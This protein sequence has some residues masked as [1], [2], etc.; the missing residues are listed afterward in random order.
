MLPWLAARGGAATAELAERFGV[1]EP[2]VVAIL[3]LAAC[4]G[5]P[6]YT[7]DRLMEVI[8]ADGWVEARLGPHLGRPR[9]LSAAEGFTVAASARA[10]LAVPGADPDGALARALCKL[11]GVLGS[12]V[13]VELDEPSFLPV[14][15]RAVEEGSALELR[16]YA[17]SRDELTSRR[18]EPS[19]VFAREGHWYLDAWC[20]LAGGRRLFRVDR[21]RQAGVVPGEEAAAGRAGSER[22]EVPETFAP[23]PEAR[24]VTLDLP[25]EGRWVTE[26]YPTQGLEEAADG[27]LRVVLAVGG[28]A[29][30]ERLLLRLGPEAVVVDPPE[31]ADVAASAATRLLA[32]YG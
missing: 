12:T 23:G 22:R 2:E 3:E 31:L 10:I 8:V 20:H 16:Y 5:L 25:P 7:P 32:R 15:R 28:V 24:L 13:D 1:E 29:W 9:R 4:C 18:V 21:I 17:A 19:G 30:L 14:V 26:S 6:P 11:E 27:R